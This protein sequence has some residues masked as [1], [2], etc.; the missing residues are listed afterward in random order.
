[1]EQLSL[2]QCSRCGELKPEN[3]F[4]WRRKARGQ[5]Q[6]FCRTCMA[7]YGRQHYEANKPLYKERA[8]ARKHRLARERGEYLIEYFKTH[9]CVDC[10]EADPVV[11]EFDH[12]RDKSCTIGAVLTHRNWESLLEEIEKCDVVCCNC[13]RRRTA[14]RGGW[15]RAVLVSEGT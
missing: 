4:A 1:M 10:G 15:T 8:L 14:T 6:Q 2:R 13:H 9:P 7:A 12:L 3:D 5:R 11:L